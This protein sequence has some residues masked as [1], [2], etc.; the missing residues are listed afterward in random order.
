[1]FTVSMADCKAAHA[2]A[3]NSYSSIADLAFLSPYATNKLK[4]FGD[5]PTKELARVFQTG[6]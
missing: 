6:R 3:P 2:P 4:R 1:M 5:Y